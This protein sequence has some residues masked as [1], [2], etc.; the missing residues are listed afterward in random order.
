MIGWG[1]AKNRLKNR[2][3][4]PVL[5]NR[6]GRTGAEKRAEKTELKPELKT[7][8]LRSARPCRK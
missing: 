2:G 8:T 4:K 6:C 3:Y 5:K 1:E 7:G